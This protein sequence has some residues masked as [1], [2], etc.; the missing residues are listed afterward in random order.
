[1][2]IHFVILTSTLSHHKV[3]Y[4]RNIKLLINLPTCILFFSLNCIFGHLSYTD[5]PSRI[6]KNQ[7]T[8]RQYPWIR[9]RMSFLELHAP[10]NAAWYINRKRHTDSN[11]RMTRLQINL[12]ARNKWK[13]NLTGDSTWVEC[14]ASVSR[15]IEFMFAEW[16]SE[17]HL[18]L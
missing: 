18:N 3:T 12:I 1:M 8:N 2:P 6:K 16:I 11:P 17:K 9:N 10:I 14:A 4:L 7:S 5:S 13:W 15:V